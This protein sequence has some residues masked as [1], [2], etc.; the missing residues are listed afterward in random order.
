MDKRI[1]FKIQS[2]LEQVSLVS[3]SIA[4]IAKQIG[5]DDMTSYQ[6]ETCLVEAIN[7]AIIH[8]YQKQH[9]VVQ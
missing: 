6:V 2:E 8:A 1:E 7:N 5:L 9:A 4:A 3:V